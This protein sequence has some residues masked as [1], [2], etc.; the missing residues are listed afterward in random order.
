MSS[1]T[2]PALLLALLPATAAALPPLVNVCWD[3]G[4]DRNARLVLPRDAWA[5]IRSLFSPAAP[6]PAA[7]R[8]RIAAAIARFERAVGPLTGTD[9]DRYENIA[10]SGLGGQQD[11]I[12]ESR[13]T[14]TYLRVLA[15]RGLLAWHGV[16]PRAHRMRWV[17][18]Q[19]WTAVIIDRSDGTR[20]AVDSWFLDNGRRPYVQRLPEWLDM[21]PLP[22]NPDAA[23]GRRRVAAAADP[24]RAGPLPR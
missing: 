19:H 23:G 6:G 5:G 22:D 16:G 8:R 24:A 14:D 9:R 12:D 4:C 1:R 20:W 17:L 7:E 15:E 10:G 11:C 3:Y 2:A 21:A 13:N 18:D